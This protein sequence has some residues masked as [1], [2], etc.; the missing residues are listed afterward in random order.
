MR[1]RRVIVL[2][3]ACAVVGIALALHGIIA[4]RS[5]TFRIGVLTLITAT[6]VHLRAAS[7]L[8]VRAVMEHQAAM[9]RLTAQDRQRY[10]AMGYKA[11]RLD[12]LTEDAPETGDA[13]V[14]MLP[15][16]RLSPQVRRDGSA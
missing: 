15:H 16:A 1:E 11:A 6:S 2:A 14:V 8:D 10:A 4:E 7:R 5:S 12:A 3:K 9:A 13:E